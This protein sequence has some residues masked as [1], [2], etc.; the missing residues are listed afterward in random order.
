MRVLHLMAGLG[1]YIFLSDAKGV[2]RE[3]SG[4][5]GRKTLVVFFSED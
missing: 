4:K 5:S 1:G 3:D 2:I